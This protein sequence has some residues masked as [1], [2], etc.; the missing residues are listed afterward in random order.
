M[1]KRLV[2][3]SDLHIG[4][5]PLDDCDEILEQHLVA[6]LLFLVESHPYCHLVINGDFLDFVQASPWEDKN[7]ESETDD[8]TPL[9]FTE[10]QS[11]SKLNEILKAHE[12]FFD[13]LSYFLGTGNNK[14]TIVPGNHDVDFFWPKVQERFVEIISNGGRVCT[15]GLT[16]HHEQVLRPHDFPEVWIEHGHQ[17]D[18]LNCFVLD[19]RPFWSSSAPPIF[20][21]KYNVPRLYEC[22]GTRFLIRFI[23]ALDKDYPFID[24]VKPFGKFLSIFATSALAPGFGSLKVTSAIWGL[25]K[26][27]SENL[28]NNQSDLLSIAENGNF[29]ATAIV[30]A[31]DQL[32]DQSSRENIIRLARDGGILKSGG[33]WVISIKDTDFC[34]SLLDLFSRE[35]ELLEGLL[36]PEKQANTL[37]LMRGFNIDESAELLRKAKR[38]ISIDT[39]VKLVVMGHTHEAMVYPHGENYINTGCWTRYLKPGTKKIPSNWDILKLNGEKYF[40]FELNYVYVD[41]S[42]S[43]STCFRTFSL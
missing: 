34:E 28:K 2:I 38:I 3:I 29:N 43:W 36:L 31:W 14:L 35:F 4:A 23:N 41:K 5:G 27:I 1:I 20:L 9:C 6:F 33:S 21:D 24:N 22:I 11:L 12:K 39:S 19:G 42:H 8:G 13:A 7:F 10:P 32:L 37:S 25:V 18:N 16:F 15:S 26:F 40:P 17:Y 30:A